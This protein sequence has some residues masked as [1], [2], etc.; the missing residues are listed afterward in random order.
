MLIIEH[1]RDLTLQRPTHTPGQWHLSAASGLVC[2]HGRAYVMGDDEHALA[3]F[4]DV[5]TPG[6]TVPLF[7]GKLPAGKKARK[8]R[9]PD[10]ETLLHLPAR[11]AWPHGA[12]LALGSGSRP[13]RL[14]GAVIKLGPAGEPQ[15]PAQLLDLASLYAPLVE[16]FDDLNIEGAFIV[17]RELVLLQRGHQGGSPNASLHYPLSTFL[18]WLHGLGPAPAPQRIR[19]HRLGTMQGVALTFT[20]GAALADGRWVFTA[21]AEATDDPVAD[22]ACV[23]SAVGVVTVQGEVQSL[24]ALPGREK[25][26]GIAAR[27]SGRTVDLC[28]VT[29]ADDPRIASRLLRSRCIL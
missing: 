20:D 11:R 4:S 17:Q 24:F 22:G 28:L 18:R 13:N 14:R 15:P 23:G 21:V 16:R 19:R 27:I 7:E 12:L 10:T 5:G 9:K 3:V 2:A 1:L 26:E 6:R 8:R 25:I 29:D